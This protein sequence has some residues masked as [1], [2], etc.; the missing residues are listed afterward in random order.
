MKIVIAGATGLVGNVLVDLCLQKGH[1][2]NFLTTSKHKILSNSNL[3]GFYWN[4]KKGEIDTACFDGA[5]VIVNLAGASIAK[6]W[7]KTYKAEILQSRTET[8]RV[9]F[10][11]L[12]N[13]NHQIKQY[14]SASAIGVYPDSLTAYYEEDTTQISSTF[15][16]KV[17][18]AWETS[19]EAFSALGLKVAI[20]RI[21]LVLANEGGALPEMTKPVKWGFGAP[22]AKGN[23]WQ[24]W[25][26]IADLAAIFMY[27]IENQFH[28]IYNAVAPNPVTQ[29]TL[30]KGIAREL[31][32]PLWL[33][34]I[35]AFF[36]KLLLGEMYLVLVESQRV[37]A[38]KIETSGYAFRYATLPVAL[39]NL[40]HKKS[41]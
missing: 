16:G 20:L 28:G 25:I 33:P 15:L 38:K 14:I 9:L 19:A 39:Q 37:S 27:S 17:V 36:L 35:P 31:K 34:H 5:E 22:F 30:I 29:K 41:R 7:T 26:H 21:G 24:S 8:A 11:A 10:Q 13:K 1:Q 2:V 3:K 12:E 40:L 18:K 32:K 6:R 4:P 23:Q